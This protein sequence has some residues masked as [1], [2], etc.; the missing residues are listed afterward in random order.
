VFACLRNAL[1]A[2][3]CD[4]RDMNT[5][6]KPQHPKDPNQGAGAYDPRQD[7]DAD[8]EQLTSR[9]VAE[10]PSQAEGDDAD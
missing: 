9:K 1:A 5:T 7:P 6:P 4:R 8:P 10:K 2:V 3:K